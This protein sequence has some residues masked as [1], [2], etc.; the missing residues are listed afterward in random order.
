MLY[1]CKSLCVCQLNSALCVDLYVGPSE[2]LLLARR[3]DIRLISLDTP[4]FLDVVLEISDVRNAIAIDY[5]P[6]ERMV[7]WTDDDLHVIRRA[8]INGSGKQ[9][10]THTHTH[11]HTESNIGIKCYFPSDQVMNCISFV[12][13]SRCCLRFGG[14]KILSFSEH[15]C[16][17]HSS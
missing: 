12:S 17:L 1:F 16:H 4:D 14:S 10:L 7:Y 13:Y 2:M 6:V 11:T 3:T 8:S 9:T 15:K 5:D